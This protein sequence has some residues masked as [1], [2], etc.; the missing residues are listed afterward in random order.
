[1]I[2]NKKYMYDD[3]VSEQKIFTRERVTHTE[4][5]RQKERNSHLITI[6]KKRKNKKSIREMKTPDK[7]HFSLSRFP[8]H[9]KRSVSYRQRARNRQNKPS[10]LSL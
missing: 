6:L 4:L 9:E 5:G 7:G 1:M 10:T 3:A 2:I 8:V